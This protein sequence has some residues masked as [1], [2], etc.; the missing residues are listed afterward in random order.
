MAEQIQL[1][2]LVPPKIGDI[3]LDPIKQVKRTA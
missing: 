3:V 2:A 1:F